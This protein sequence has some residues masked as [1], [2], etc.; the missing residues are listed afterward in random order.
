MS[1]P[2]IQDDAYDS[3]LAALR[4]TEGRLKGAIAYAAHVQALLR[5]AC[6]ILE[7]MEVEIEVSEPLQFWWEKEKRRREAS[8]SGVLVVGSRGPVRDATGPA[9]GS[10]IIVDGES[11]G[12][13]SNDKPV[14]LIVPQEH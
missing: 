6:D 4:D 10:R 7:K 8:A 2:F 14:E 9:E 5:E 1:K 12:G 3:L 11:T 13:P